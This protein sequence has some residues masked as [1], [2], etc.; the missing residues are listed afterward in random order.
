MC[1]R[2]PLMGWWLLGANG[3]GYHWG[4]APASVSLCSSVSR[5]RSFYYVAQRAELFALMRTEK[6]GAGLLGGYP[7]LHKWGHGNTHPVC[8]QFLSFSDTSLCCKKNV[9]FSI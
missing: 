4:F 5:Q 9:L 7:A 8:Q 6:V 2:A 1:P 3:A